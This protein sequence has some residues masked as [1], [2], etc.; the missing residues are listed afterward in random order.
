MRLSRN[1]DDIRGR[2]FL[3][4]YDYIVFDFLS[5]DYLQVEL[6]LS[7]AAMAMTIH[8][9]A[10][11]PQARQRPLYIPSP[12]RIQLD[13]AHRRIRQDPERDVLPNYGLAVQQPPVHSL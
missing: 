13:H 11:R 2:I 10:R 3:P 6:A 12:R 5:E 8:D 9:V 4:V 1:E 7:Y